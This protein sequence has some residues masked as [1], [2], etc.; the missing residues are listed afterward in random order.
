MFTMP[1]PRRR[2]PLANQRIVDAWNAAHKVGTPV[3]LRRDNGTELTT[4]TRSEAW[5]M[6]EHTPVVMVEGIAGGYALERVT[7]IPKERA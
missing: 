7:P 6:G 4:K 5:V 2:D 1:K 3:I